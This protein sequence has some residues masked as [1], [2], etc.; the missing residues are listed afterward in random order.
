MT[1]RLFYEDSHLDSFTAEVTACVAKG[2]SYGVVLDRTAFFPEGGGQ[3]ADTGFLNALEVMDVQEADNEIYHFLT[4]PLEVGEKV[5][6]R[7]NA[8]QRFIKMQQHSGE[9]IVSGLVHK[10][11]GFDNVGFHLGTDESTLDFNGFLTEE[12]LRKIEQEANEAVVS[13]RKIEIF[14]PSQ[15]ERAELEYRSK[16]Q[17]DTDLR[18]VRIPGYDVCACCAP[19]VV[20]TGEIGLIKLVSASKYK[21][22]TRVH[23]LCGFRALEDYNKKEKNITEISALLSAKPYE[24]ADAVRHVQK[25]LMDVKQKGISFQNKYLN[26]KFSYIDQGVGHFLFF[27]DPMDMNLVRKYIN[28]GM[29]HCDGICGAF[30]GNDKNGYNYILGSKTID[31]RNLLKEFHQMFPGKGGGRPEMVQG[32]VAGD[33]NQLQQYINQIPIPTP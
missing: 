5:H 27:D 23:M 8:S 1:E 3:Y 28:E 9:H 26:L 7:I 2:G 6:G 13:N 17:I 10:H 22:G 30:I 12:N 29:N 16:I 20:Y 14:Y 31:L 33:K 21:G 24:T 11:F 15:E 25:E 18:I 19:H 4:Q 32:S